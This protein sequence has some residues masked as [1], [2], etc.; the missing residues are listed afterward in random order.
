LDENGSGRGDLPV[1]SPAPLLQIRPRTETPSRPSIPPTTAKQKGRE[2]ELLFTLCLK[3]E[4][5]IRALH[6]SQVSLKSQLLSLD[7]RAVR[8]G[9]RAR[10]ATVQSGRRR[11]RERRE[12]SPGEMAAAWLGVKA[13]PFTY[14]AHA[15]AAVA[16]VL[17]LVWCVHFRGGLALEAQNKN[18]VFNVS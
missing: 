15:L 18:L 11:R 12:E 14:A 3:H 6:A 13:A 16:A 1:K 8:G 4:A 7:R 9:R 5:T 17:V 2:L 10:A